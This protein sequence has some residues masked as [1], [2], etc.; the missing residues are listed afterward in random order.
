MR[1]EAGTFR[2]GSGGERAPRVDR[3]SG[4][5]GSQVQNVLSLP[6][7]D[8]LSERLVR[9][10]VQVRGGVDEIDISSPSSRP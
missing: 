2:V 8:K 9:V 1:F 5:A 10:L 4:L 3:E 7:T 6:V